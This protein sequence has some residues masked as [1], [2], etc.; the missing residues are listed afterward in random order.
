M[1]RVHTLFTAACLPLVLGSLVLLG[2]CAPARTGVFGNTMFSGGLPALAITPARDSGLE[3]VASGRLLAGLETDTSQQAFARV[4]Y[5]VFGA[6][7]PNDAKGAAATKHGHV[8]VTE[9][10]NNYVWEFNVESWP[11]RNEVYLRTVNF[12]GQ[13][14]TEHLLYADGTGDW[15]SEFW[16]NNGFKVPERWAG[17]RW[18][19]DYANYYRVVVEYR[20]ALPSCL[21]VANNEGQS[22]FVH[23]VFN[24]YTQ[25]CQKELQDFEARAALAFEVQ[26]LRETEN[27]PEPGSAL[28]PVF[29]ELP[30]LPPDMKKLVGTAQRSSRGG[31]DMADL[32]D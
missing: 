32:R 23:A 6:V 7:A 3:P 24:A 2:G 1:T 14:W 18:S 8:M 30:K 25:E 29:A 4:N 28:R 26:N 12:G 11:S 9:L 31:G 27:I 15:F 16:R 5:A 20:E 17:K 13:E 10:S 19:R 22:Y 21:E